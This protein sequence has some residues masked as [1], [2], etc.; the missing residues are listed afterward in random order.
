VPAQNGVRRDNRRHLHQQPT[1]E[2]RAT[3]GQAS[4][5]VVGEPQPVVLQLRLQHAVLFA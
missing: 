5:L 1:T 4:S 2:S 3:G